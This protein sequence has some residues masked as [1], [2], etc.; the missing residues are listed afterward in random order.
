LRP[1]PKREGVEVED[2]A[3]LLFFLAF[4]NLSGSV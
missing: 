4:P 3:L 2:R 1:G